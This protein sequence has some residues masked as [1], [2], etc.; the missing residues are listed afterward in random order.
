MDLLVPL[1]VGSSIAAGA[2]VIYPATMYALDMSPYIYANTRCSARSGLILNK[3]QYDSFIAASSQKEVLAMLEDSYYSYIIE[4]ASAFRSFSQMLDKDLYNT[5]QWLYKIVPDKIK[6]LLKSMKLKFEI[7]E[8]KAILNKV[9]KN[10]GPGELHFIED[11]MLKLKLEGVK[12]FTSFLA[13][14]ENTPYAHLFIN[15]SP[16]DLTSLN[17][18]LDMFYS[19]TVL[20][21]I[22]KCKDEKAAMP[23]KEYWAANI[24]LINLRLV[25]RKIASGEED[26]T[27]LD[28]GLLNKNA[29]LG[30]SDIAQLDSILSSS[31]YNP[32]IESQNPFK[33]EAGIYTYF[34]K[35]ASDVG[36]KYTIK[37]G[38]VV[39]FIILKE[40]ETRNL[41]IINKLK[42]ENYP[43]GEIEKLIVA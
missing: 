31:V 30:V 18:S 15:A 13:V 7:N 35:I 39:K 33:I 17:N 38:A 23:F 12:D 21:E 24:D 26:V 5:Y 29:L 36:A 4:H 16:E 25:L 22:K 27:L 28:G 32:F 10:Q 40:L 11:E 41:N 37:A 1:V 6:P 43:A 42:M 9:I 2:F 20:N 19:S 3:Q 34:K 14:M 8:L